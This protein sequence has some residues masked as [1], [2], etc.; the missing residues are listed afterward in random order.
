MRTQL[1]D[2][3]IVWQLRIKKIICIRDIVCIYQSINNQKVS[4][5]RNIW[6]RPDP[7]QRLLEPSNR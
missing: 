4:H 1:S 3:I 5:G 7:R 6:R 2:Q